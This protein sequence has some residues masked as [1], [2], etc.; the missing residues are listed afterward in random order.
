VGWVLLFLAGGI[1]G[2]LCDQIHVR[3]GALSYPHPAVFDQAWW[4]APQFGVGILVVLTAVRP[5]A[6]RAPGRS[7]TA[8][9]AVLFL[10]AYGA[11]GLFHRWP[12]GLTV[13]LPIAWLVRLAVDDDRGLL[14]VWS[15]LLALGGT[16]YEGTLAG[17]GA[18]HYTR[19]DVYHVPMW[20]PGIYLN[21]AALALDVGRSLF[22]REKAGPVRARLSR[23]SASLGTTGSTSRPS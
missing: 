21:G 9:D 14:L 17:T 11:T 8:I 7:R 16:L 2:A 15:L 10:A 20:L 3:S 1:G 23:T 5:F 4:V 22:G 19:P 13:V 12:V 6:R 18:F